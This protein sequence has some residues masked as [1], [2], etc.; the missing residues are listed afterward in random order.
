[1]IFPRFNAMSSLSLPRRR[2]IHSIYY[3][4]SFILNTEHVEVCTSVD[5]KISAEEEGRSRE[6]M[7]ASRNVLADV[8]ADEENCF[9]H[10]FERLALKKSSNNEMFEAIKVTRF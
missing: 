1:M 2:N 6:E 9:G 5:Y 4:Q 3:F 10:S 8:L 7:D